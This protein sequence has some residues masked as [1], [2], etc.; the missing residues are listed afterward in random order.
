MYRLL[1]KL[2]VVPAS[3]IRRNSPEERRTDNGLIGRRISSRLV[4]EEGIRE[5][6]TLAVG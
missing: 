3:V 2:T 1:R 6:V 5:E 4:N